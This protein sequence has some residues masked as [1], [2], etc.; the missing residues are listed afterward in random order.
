MPHKSNSNHHS[1]TLPESAGGSIQKVLY[2]FLLLINTL[3]HG[4]PSLWEFFFPAKLKGQGLV[5]DHWSSD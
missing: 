4:F 3:F 2:Y 1:T 5:T